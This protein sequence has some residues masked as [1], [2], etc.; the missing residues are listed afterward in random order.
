MTATTVEHSRVPE[1]ITNQKYAPEL[2]LL[3]TISLWSSTFIVTKDQLE[4]FHPMAFIFARFL[5]MTVMAFAIM[6]IQSRGL[7]LPQRRHLLHFIGAGL[8]G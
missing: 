1:T 2:A 3:I 5:L 6:V 7:P 4:V 8:S